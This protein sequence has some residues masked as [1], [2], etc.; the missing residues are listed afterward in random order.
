MWLLNLPRLF[1]KAE[2]K[3]KFTSLAKLGRYLRNGELTNFFGGHGI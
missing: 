3:Q 1:P 2:L